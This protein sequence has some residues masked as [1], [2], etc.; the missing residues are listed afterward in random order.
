MSSNS[1][2]ESYIKE[3]LL[4]KQALSLCSSIAEKREREEAAFF[5]AVRVLIIRIQNQ[6][7][8]KKLSLPEINAKINELLKQST[9]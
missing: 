6:G 8:N 4:L 1:F 7:G 5:E 9:K 2:K 3:A